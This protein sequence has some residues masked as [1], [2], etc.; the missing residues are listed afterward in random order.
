MQPFRHPKIKTLPKKSWFANVLY[1]TLLGYMKF[2]H[3]HFYYRKIQ[4][5]DK[6]NVPPVGTPLL[7]VSNHQN[8]LNDPLAIEFAFSDRVVTIFTRADAF[9]HLLTGSESGI[10]FRM[11]QVAS[12]FDLTSDRGRIEYASAAAKLLSTL[13]NAVEREVYTVRAAEAAGITPDAMKLEVSRAFK[14]KRRQEEKAQERKNLNPAAALQ[15]RERGIRYDNL[16]SA[17]AEEGVL[18][19][20]VLDDSLFGAEPPLREEEFSS[21]LLGRF[22]TALWQQVQESG[23]T[24]LAAL[25]GD[26]TSEEINH[27]SGI[28]QKPESAKNGAQALAD[29]CRIIQ[30]AHKADGADPLVSAMEKYKNKG[31]GGKQNG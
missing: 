25:A 22:F 5:L 10:D 3:D 9:E 21:P 17:L 7:V 27:L 16:R 29:Y 11:A 8:A 31:N 4:F 12:Q 6:G 1:L 19:L 20:L 18:R 13:P 26:F 2:V 15:P 24:N 30:D 28:L 23:K 14:Q